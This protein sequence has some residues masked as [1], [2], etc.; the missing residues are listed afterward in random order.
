[1]DYSHL[2]GKAVTYDEGN[3][4]K[5]RLIVVG[6]E[7]GVGCTI[8]KEENPDDIVLCFIGPM[9][10]SFNFEEDPDGSIHKE[11]FDALIP[12]L[13]AG[14]IDGTVFDEIAKKN[15]QIAVFSPFMQA[16]MGVHDRCPFNQ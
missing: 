4:I 9:S 13:E 11:Y 15:D 12:Q 10:P 1:M 7:E 14:H 6:C 2:E 3:G 5:H 16:V 8:V